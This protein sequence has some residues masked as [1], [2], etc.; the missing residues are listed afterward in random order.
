MQT[1]KFLP[2]LALLCLSLGC[3][4]YKMQEIYSSL[5][6]GNPEAA[7]VY[8]KEN[9][10][11]KPNLPFLFEQGVVAHYANRFPE[12]NAALAQ[13]ESISEDLYTR[14]VSKEALALLTTDLLR[15]YPGTR[16]ERLLSHYYRILNYIYLNQ[17]DGALVE[18]RRATGLIQY[19][20]NEHEEYDFF[21]AA[22]LAYLSGLLYE[23]NGEWNNAFISYQQAEKYYQR[24]ST[25]TGVSMPEDIGTSLVRLAWKLGFTEEL[26]RYR[27]QYGTPLEHAAGYGELI[28][29]Y[30]S[31]YVPPKYEERLTFP[32]LKTDTTTEAFE[33]GNEEGSNKQ[34]TSDFVKTLLSRRGKSYPDAQLEY[35]LHVAM[36][37]IRSNRPELTG[38][39]VAV[40]NVQQ[41]GVLVADIQTMAIKTFNSQQP[42]ILFRTMTR[43][44]LKYLVY[45][46]AKAILDKEVEEAE[47]KLEE[48]EKREDASAAEKKAARDNV[49]W[50]KMW[51]RMGGRISNVV[52]VATEHADTRSW[53]TLPNQI[54]LVRMLLPEGVYNV[55]LLFL[56][57]GMQ[58]SVS[59]TLRNVEIFSNRVTFLNYRTY[60]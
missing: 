8:L 23:T 38:I 6:A 16:Y 48:V 10:P 24:A 53:R 57:A 3:S 9:T 31:G 52:N 27:S 42:T 45:R 4:S 34:A 51:G 40:G 12:S 56:E 2:F 49:H 21:G 54:F 11:K 35:L 1:G 47:K 18:C 13:A 39:A 55:N 36:P 25:K 44:L 5:E 7:F 14:S 41:T 37:A 33:E 58:N 29:F 50:T 26:A 32:I 43:A 30:E 60:D 59:Q 20:I 15:P 28:L 19:Y 17:L 22:F 46:V